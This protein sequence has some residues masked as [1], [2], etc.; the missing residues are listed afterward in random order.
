VNASGHSD[1]CVC[2][3]V[4]AKPQ[5]LRRGGVQGVTLGHP[6]G[7]A[8]AGHL[9]WG[10]GLLPEGD[11]LP[12]GGGAPRRDVSF[13]EVYHLSGPVR[14]PSAALRPSRRGGEG[15]CG[16]RW[17]TSPPSGAGAARAR[18]AAPLTNTGIIRGGESSPNM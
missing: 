10:G 6:V 9:G 4:T 18:P 17:S 11:A 13:S 8:Y 15:E 7:P 3:C 2:V 1:V 14:G 5:G 12:E 16:G